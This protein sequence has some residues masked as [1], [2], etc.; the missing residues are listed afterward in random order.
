MSGML[1]HDVK[2]VMPKLSVIETHQRQHT[3]LLQHILVALQKCDADECC[4]VPEGINL[5]LKSI[6]KLRALESALKDEDTVRQ[7]A[8]ITY[9]LSF[10]SLSSVM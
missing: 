8:F 9:A 4:D 2:T 10:R 3:Q 7:L 5:P 6:R 1:L